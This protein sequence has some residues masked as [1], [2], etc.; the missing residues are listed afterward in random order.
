MAAVSRKKSGRKARKT[1]KVMAGDQ[2]DL[3]QDRSASSKEIGR[4]KKRL[5][6]GPEEFRAIRKRNR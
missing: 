4:R 5:L 3:L 1:A 2:L 6:E